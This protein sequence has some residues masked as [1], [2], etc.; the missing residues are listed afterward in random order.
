MAVAPKLPWK[1]KRNSPEDPEEF[2][3][4]LVEHLEE[5]RTR[6]MR[7]LAIVVAGWIIGWFLEKPLYDHLNDM[8]QKTVQPIMLAKHID[9]KNIF[10]NA[11]EPFM[12]KFKLSMIIGIIL[13]FPFL[14]LELWAFIEPA[15]KPS[16]RKPFKIAAPLSFVLFVTGATAC[17]FIIP[18][19]IGWFATYIEE[20][21]GAGLYQ[22]VPDLIFFTMKLLLAFGIGFQ[23]PLIVYALNALGLLEAETLSKHWRKATFGVFAAAMI[24]TPSNDF[25]TM[26][27]MAIPVSILFIITIL[28]VKVASKKRNKR[29]AAE[30]NAEL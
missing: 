6:V 29:A 28:V 15:L 5:L 17:W 10:T 14:I 24:V 23:L 21:P 22:N 11:T 2:R 19:A 20:F 16:E 13:A 25:F 18:N 27:S 8:I 1:K 3:L 26:L 7:S 12:L 9:F 30:D 4:T